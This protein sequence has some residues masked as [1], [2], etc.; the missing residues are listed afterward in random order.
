MDE[1]Q[2]TEKSFTLTRKIFFP[3][4]IYYR[5]L[6]EADTLNATIKPH[7]YRW[8]DEDETGIVRSNVKMVGSWHSAVDMAERAEYSDLVDQILSC[9]Q[10]V[11]DDLGYAL[12]PEKIRSVSG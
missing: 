11:H 6:P 9:A 3:T 10:I 2:G 1:P 4:M 5:D 8:R 12:E 7:I